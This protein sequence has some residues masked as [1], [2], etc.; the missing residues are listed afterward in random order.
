MTTTAVARTAAF[1]TPRQNEQKS[2]K[3]LATPPPP[4]LSSPACAHESR[5]G[6]DARAEKVAEHLLSDDIIRRGHIRVGLPLHFLHAGLIQE[7]DA[8]WERQGKDA[9]CTVST[10][11]LGKEIVRE[12]GY[13]CLIFLCLAALSSWTLLRLGVLKTGPSWTAGF[14]RGIF[15]LV[16]SWLSGSV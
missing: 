2:V 1:A 7:L 5:A 9:Q 16:F 15:V 11:L 6:D 3:A 10:R 13:Y 12:E 4:P 14:E 8:V